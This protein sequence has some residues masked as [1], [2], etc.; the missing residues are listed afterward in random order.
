M[1]NGESRVIVD[2]NPDVLR[3]SMDLWRKATDMEIPLADQFKIHFMERRRALL[4]G[5]VKTG[6]AWT[7]ILRDM[8][9]VEGDDQLERLRD[10]VTGFVTWAD[11]G[12]K[13][14]DAL[15]TDD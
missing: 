1:S 12:L 4:E 9:A 15:A 11:E 10:E 14:L 2:F 8:K 6:A 5:F 7:M 3:A 13:S